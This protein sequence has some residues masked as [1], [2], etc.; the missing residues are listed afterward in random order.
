MWGARPAWE[1]Y[2]PSSF[3]ASSVSDLVRRGGSPARWIHRASIRS[4]EKSPEVGEMTCLRLVRVSPPEM[5]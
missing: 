4:A 2:A 3:C 5:P 1:I